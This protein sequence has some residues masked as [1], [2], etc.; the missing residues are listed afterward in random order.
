[1][2][3]KIIIPIVILL[4]LVI[5][6]LTWFILNNNKV[7]STITLD[8][9]PS[10][11]LQLNK[12]NEVVN[13]IP[14]NDDAKVII[15]DSLK[16]LDLNNALDKITANVIDKGFVKDDTATIIIHTEGISSKDV[17][18]VLTK[19]FEYKKV[20][21]NIIIVENITKEDEDLAK[22]YGVS[23]A[24]ASYINTITKEN[25]NIDAELLIEK[26]V[27]ELEE[28]KKTGFY[29]D[30]GYTLEGA[31]CVK[32][33]GR[34]AAKRGDVC[35]G[36]YA[37]YKGKCY[38]ETGLIETDELICFEH[39]ILVD[40][41][42]ILKLEE[43]PEAEYECTKGEL[44]RKGDVNP[45]GAKDNEK[46]YCIDK[47]T[48]KP[49]T[50]KCLLNSGYIM[51]NGNCYNGPAPTINGG[52]PNGDVLR[53]G[54]CYSKDDGTQYQCPDGHI[55]DKS[56]ELCPDTLT[57]I[58]PTVKGYKCN[59]GFTLTDNKCIKEE[60]EQAFH[61]RVCPDGYTLIGENNCYDLSKSVP[62]ENGYYCEK[63]NSRMENN[64]CIILEI[65]E[66][67]K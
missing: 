38:R 52:C 40:G 10:I 67:Y 25:E 7:V 45:I 34:E 54:K 56:L 28:T 39:R 37:E 36:G 21:S 42:C 26:P 13:I 57:Y 22:K 48:G 64:E 18:S 24:K 53:N 50:L 31:I 30:K 12:K 41:N 6:G 3:K 33:I 20:G 29:C 4:I 44:M 55:Y 16:G 59:D 14:L 1:M 32:E 66:A 8:I 2:K 49:P 43:K 5:C 63:D 23:S 51:I 47:S 15:D 9:N 61:K 46:M 17:E 65:N 35:P 27:D 19:S 60:I 58:N 11:E 62:K